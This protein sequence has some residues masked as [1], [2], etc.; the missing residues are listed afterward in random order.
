MGIGAKGAN[1]KVNKQMA[2]GILHAYAFYVADHSEVVSVLRRKSIGCGRKETET[3]PWDVIQI[4]LNCG[5]QLFC[6]ICQLK[7]VAV[8]GI[9]F[10]IFLVLQSNAGDVIVQRTVKQKIGI[11]RVH[12]IC[13]V[14]KTFAV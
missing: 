10:L 12:I 13:C 1:R 6:K 3:V 2:N 7:H 4:C 9:D 5:A 8:F 14:H 11:N